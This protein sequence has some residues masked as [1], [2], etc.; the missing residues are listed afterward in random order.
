[1]T[2][3][4]IATRNRHK[5]GE[6]Q[7]ILG[8]S[9]SY[10]TLDD[11]PEAPAVVEDASTFSG[12]ACKKAIIL[13]KWLGS[14]PHRMEAGGLFVMADDSG[15]EVDAL[16]GAP[17]VLS[18]RF[19]AGEQKGAN[20]QDADN[21]HKLLRMLVS[22]PDEAR[23][24]RFRCVIAVTPVLPPEPGMTSPTCLADAHEIQTQTFEGVC[25]GRIGRKPCGGQGFG[26]DP[27]FTPD[28][29]SVTFAE[30]G[31]EVK[32]Q[33]SHRARALIEFQRH[34]RA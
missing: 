21:N 5:V 6:I 22:V 2:T 18:A 8:N 34:F 3:L 33:L 23:T 12:N 16:N 32:N 10:V 15:L 25:E 17:G 26:Y 1:M 9:F 27:L 11:F 24:A 4:L 29:Y 19:A 7:G 30:M 13:A 28:G 31:A 20:S 14:H